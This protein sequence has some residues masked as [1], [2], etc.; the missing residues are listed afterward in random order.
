MDTTNYYEQ[1]KHLFPGVSL[2]IRKTAFDGYFVSER[3]DVISTQ[4]Y[5]TGK[6]LKPF[7]KLMH[8]SVGVGTP[9][10]HHQV[11]RLVAKTFLANPD[12]KPNVCHKNGNP[13][14][15]HYKNLY[16]GTQRENM[17]DRYKHG[18]MFHGDDHWNSKITNEIAAKIKQLAKAEVL[19][20]RQIIEK[21]KA[22]YG[23]E[24]SRSRITEIKHDRCWKHV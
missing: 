21:I 22:D 7:K 6:I 2:E 1:F 24:V 19:S 5:S 13:L 8:L 17:A 16:W 15:N 11:H 20:Q 10:R 4:R 9:N 23:M 12:N 3:G 14:Q 18:T